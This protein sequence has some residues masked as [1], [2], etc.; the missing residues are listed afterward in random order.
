MRCHQAFPAFN[1]SVDTHEIAQA[2][3]EKGR[4]LLLDFF[5]VCD[6]AT[7]T[8]FIEIESLCYVIEDT[9]IVNDQTMRF[10]LIIGSVSAADGLKESVV[11]H[12]LVKVHCLKNRSVKT[13]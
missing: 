10:T 13:G 12:R 8:V 9:N 5:D 6:D 4:E 3:F 2:L 11:L 7:H 1:G